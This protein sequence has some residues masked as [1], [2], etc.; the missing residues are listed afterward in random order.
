VTGDVP[1][2]IPALGVIAGAGEE[3]VLV[4]EE[5]EVPGRLITLDPYSMSGFAYC[6][7][8]AGAGPSGRALPSGV[9]VALFKPSLTKPPFIKLALGVMLSPP[10]PEY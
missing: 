10:I 7:I 9:Y 3:T 6:P 1:F 5:T 8:N 2:K 4:G